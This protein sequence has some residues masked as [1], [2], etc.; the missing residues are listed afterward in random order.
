MITQITKET[1]LRV[2]CTHAER[3]GSKKLGPSYIRSCRLMQSDQILHVI[4][5]RENFAE[6]VDC[7]GST[8]IAQP[9]S[10]GIVQKHKLGE[11]KNILT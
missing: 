11:M 5:G 1:I 9:L 3:T 7:H 8:V 2:I 10:L 6:W 4:R